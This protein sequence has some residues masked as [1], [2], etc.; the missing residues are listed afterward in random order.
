MPGPP[1]LRFA[2]SPTGTLHI[3]GARTALFNWLYARR[4]GGTFVLRIED[5]DAARSTDASLAAILDGLRWLGLDWDEGPD[6]GGPHGPYRQTERRSIYREH[7]ERLIAEGKAYRCRCSKEELDVLR[8]ASTDAGVQFR[9]P[10]TCRSANVPASE[11][12]VVRIRMPELGATTFE[13]LV[14]GRITTPHDTLQDEV[15]LR[16]DGLPLYNFGAVVDDATMQIDIVARGDD[17]INNTARQ[18]L[19]YEALGWKPPRFAHLPMILGEDKKRLSKRHGA[20]SVT[21]YR[22][23]GYLPHALVNYLVRLGWS[24]DDK[25][26]IFSLDDLLA[27][28]DFERVAKSAAVFNP[29][30]LAWLNQHWMKESPPEAL[31]T[32]VSKRLGALGYEAPVDEKLLAI[33]R[34][35]QPRVQT[36]AEMA[37]RAVVFYREGVASFDPKAVAKFLV[38]KFRPHLEAARAQLASLDPYDP[39]AMEAWARTY[40]ETQ[41]VGLGKVAQPL[42]VALV[43]GTASPGI[44]E[45]IAMVGRDEALSRIDTALEK[46]GEG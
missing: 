8:K 40:A 44:F 25:S 27:H 45:T 37:E 19:M 10:G 4:M 14:R 35:L 11:P 42:R 21:A 7:A 38:P 32:D 29:E 1:R 23:A 16:R 41:G 22:E 2:P 34:A 3:G 13:D 15:I 18:I 31:A 12:H 5:T 43:G 6:V 30:K 46:M 9:Y 33:V 28:F 17:H 36:L 26:E 39:E 20:V 24:L